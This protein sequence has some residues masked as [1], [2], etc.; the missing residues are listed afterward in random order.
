M[1]LPPSDF[2]NWDFGGS[3][4]L[5]ESFQCGFC[6]LVFHHV[7]HQKPTVWQN[8]DPIAYQET[9]QTSY[10]VRAWQAGHWIKGYNELRGLRGHLLN[11]FFVD[12]NDKMGNI[13]T[14]LIR[15]KIPEKL[16]SCKALF[17]FN[18]ASPHWC[19]IPC[20]QPLAY[21]VMCQSLNN[22]STKLTDIQIFPEYI[23]CLEG[24]LIKNST[25]YKF[26]W[27]NYTTEQEVCHK[28]VKNFQ[29]LFDAPQITEFPPVI[30]S[31]TKF[32]VV[33][34]YFN[35]YNYNVHQGT[36]KL[37]GGYCITTFPS[38]EITMKPNMFGC[39]NGAYTSSHG[40][41]DGE[42]DCPGGSLDNEMNLCA[43]SE[44]TKGMQTCNYLLYAALDGKCEPYIITKEV[45]NPEISTPKNHTENEDKT[46]YFE[47]K[48]GQRI[49]IGSVNDLTID[50]FPK[51][52]DEVDYGL[53]S[54][55]QEGIN[56]HCLQCK[57]PHQLP[58]VRCYPL[59]YNVSELCTYQLNSV[60]NLVP[61]RTGEH[62][63]EC[64]HFECNMMFKCPQYYC[65]AWSYVCNGV[66]D[67]PGG[68]DESSKHQC[69]Q[70]RSCSGLF[71]CK[72]YQTCIHPGHVCDKYSHC[73]FGDD[74]MSCSLKE[75]TCPQTCRCLQF[76]VVC[77]NITINSNVLYKITPFR[78]IFVI[79][80]SG[81]MFDEKLI[82]TNS[83]LFS[84]T[85]ANLKHVCAVIFF[86]SFIKHINI[87]ANQIELIGSNCFSESKSL[88][89]LDLSVNEIAFL[90]EGTFHSLPQLMVLILSKNP[91]LKI[92]NNVI[93]GAPKLSLISL[94]S[95]CKIKIHHA[96]F[97]SFNLLH[98]ETDQFW[99]C[100]L[101]PEEVQ[102]S[103]A[104]PWYYSCNNILESNEIKVTFL[105]V[106]VGI[107]VL[108]VMSMITQ[109]ISVRKASGK[110]PKAFKNLAVSINVAD[111]FCS[112]PLASLW[113]A[114][115][116]F[117]G[118]FSSGSAKWQ[119]SSFCHFIAFHFVYFSFISPALLCLLSHIRLELTENPFSTKLREA[120]LVVQ[121]IAGFNIVCAT[122][123]LLFTLSI[124]AVNSLLLNTWMAVP[125]CLPF[126]DPKNENAATKVVTCTT[127][128]VQLGSVFFILYKHIK[129]YSTLIESQK[130]LESSKS[131]SIS[132]TSV[133]FQ[134]IVLSGSNALC[135]IPASVVLL[136]CL[137][138]EKY[139]LKMLA[140]TI[141]TVFPINS[142]L[143]PIV[144]IVTTIRKIKNN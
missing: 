92:G 29:Y 46:E 76:A 101:A 20:D 97:Q 95:L 30:L 13:R 142:V 6:F 84:L 89:L 139:P 122:S 102:C 72:G 57:N 40:V 73:P 42:S 135:W 60:G 112:V 18:L 120:K 25:C 80:S 1:I 22:S 14:M 74:E 98:I 9:K 138:L 36:N 129:L 44:G 3:A 41:C 127:I 134:I 53:M 96:A 28:N 117:T 128:L 121:H 67:C 87:S 88:T 4:V 82:L 137:V 143:N 52:E 110:R 109:Q 113:I 55:L 75:V 17:L 64:G 63:Q 65:I 11:V 47:C 49:D 23:F 104:R 126:V 26:E 27:H 38:E 118:K 2:L 140:W 10:S 5:S 56:S 107:V 37:S 133:M 130:S 21:N 132:H 86:G 12:L 43:S 58:C 144:F 106:S 125:F 70:G 93:Q 59:C 15:R 66:W 77:K 33:T 7:I 39:S 54:D 24:N 16:F 50:C 35:E 131:K 32:V 71:K 51:G 123:G 119:S 79:G 83:L 105:C 31:D 116:V 100:C 8:K 111:I 99:M 115:L 103:A 34:R 68:T 45:T 69:G 62:I 114:D 141:G 81:G 61:C 124:W 94:E 48:N 78:A 91:I 19:S 90:H 136:T 108:N 85:K